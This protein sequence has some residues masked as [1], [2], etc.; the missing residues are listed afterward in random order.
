MTDAMTAPMTDAEGQALYDWLL[1]AR[2][3]PSLYAGELMPGLFALWAL[4]GFADARLEELL[5]L[6]R[7]LLPHEGAAIARS[8]MQEARDAVQSHGREAR[9]LARLQERLGYLPGSFSGAM[10]LSLSDEERRAS[11]AED[12]LQC[13][14]LMLA[15]GYALTSLESPGE[16]RLHHAAVIA[17]GFLRA[18]QEGKEEA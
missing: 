16:A 18:R 10:V 14:G 13:L 1:T 17:R 2:A 5:A 6:L 4:E 9:L 3:W 11:G 7:P 12:W 8:L 15:M